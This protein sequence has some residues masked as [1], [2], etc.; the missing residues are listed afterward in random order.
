MLHTSRR[1]RWLCVAL[2]AGLVL[3]ACG[4]SATKTAAKGT[5]DKPTKSATK[6]SSIK[7]TWL[8]IAGDKG[9]TGTTEI[10]LNPPKKAGDFRVEFSANEVGGIGS[11][12]QAGAW[13]A[14]VS[15]TMLM[16]EPLEGEF[17]F[18]TDGRVDG[19][20]AGA[21]TTAGII[22]L[23][24]GDKF[25]DKVTMTGTINVTGMVGPVGGIPEKIQGAADAGFKTVLIPL[26]QRNTQNHAGELVDVVKEGE[27]L[28]V[29][30]KEVGDIYEAY[31]ELTGNDIDVPGVSRDPR[32]ADK[33]YD[34]V[35]PQVDATLSRYGAS[36]ATYQQLPAELRTE[37][38]ATGIPATAEGYAAKAEDLQRQGLQAGAYSLADQAAITM[39]TVAAAG[40]MVVPI[41]TQG[42]DGLDTTF[43]Q[44]LDTSVT[45]KKFQAFLDQLSTFDPKN[46]ADV[47]GLVEAYAMTFDSYSL[48]QFAQGQIQAIKEKYD[49]DGY[50]SVDELFT[51]LTVPV[52]FSQLAKSTITSAGSLYEVGRDNPGAK[53]SKDVNLA[54]V[55]DFFRR[56]AD[57]NFTA[58]KEGVIHPAAESNGVSDDVLTN[59][60]ANIDLNVA[61]AVAQPQIQPLIED[62]LGPKKPNSKYATLGYGLSNFIRNQGLMDKYYNN[63][64]L[65]ENM[66]VTGV[67]YD[68]VLSRG[69]D[70]GRQQ[71]AA[72]VA[73]LRDHKTEP[74]IS[75]AKYE[76]AGLLRGSDLDDQF[77]A[78]DLYRGGFVTTRM[79]SYLAGLEGKKAAGGSGS[80]DGSKSVDSNGN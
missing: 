32:L 34:K 31:A 62:Y 4:G 20:S 39:E 75:V 61:V 41:Y 68:A 66:N 45:E 67:Q 7:V 79:M 17:G 55:G 15:A 13:N 30:V 46:V 51:E 29:D 18:E 40:Q 70:L 27:R 77:S 6:S 33:S 3:G 72:E 53:L 64:V 56:A 5:K 59:H 48:L 69:L 2:A 60:L 22:A 74:V 58:F 71:L 65:D 26:G 10:T 44:A 35:K 21:L 8:A 78:T 23:F 47:E 11:Q 25:Q 9:T 14:A 63:A 73:V 36:V 16:G 80:D 1:P 38:D 24:R 49:N 12:S 28:G 76:V 52:M 57:A 42:L 37:L 54:Q 19:P 43:N 50:T